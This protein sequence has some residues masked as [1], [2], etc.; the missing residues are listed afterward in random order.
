MAQENGSGQHVPVLLQAVLEGLNVRND[1]LYVDG[2]FGRGGHS[3]EI[4][5]RLGTK[6]RLLAI[7]RDPQAV[8]AAGAL[9][10]GDARF[11][12]VRG[13]IAELSE[14]VAEH[15]MLGKVDGLLFDLGVSSPQLDDPARGFSFRTD[16]PL[17]MRMDPT[18]GHSAADWLSRA[19]ETSL[20]KV[21]AEYG[22]ERFAARIARAIVTARGERAITRTSQ[23]ADIV[24]ASVPAR[25]ERIHPATRTFQALRIAV[26]DEL[27]QLERGLSAVPS[28]LARG[29]RFCAI[30]FHSLEDRRVKRF[31]RTASQESEQYR[32][33]PSIP[34][35]HRPP[36]HL[37]GKLVRAAPDEIAVNPRARSARLRVAERC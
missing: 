36:M 33:L 22:E 20:K 31:L 19:N 25:G 28:L 6:G 7:D 2:T 1:G 13:E 11:E 26:N 15:K 18:S 14:I 17:D 34:E 23:L 5:E 9:L 3:R 35:Q 32:G 8:E 4:L 27:G 29:G 24:A 12:I 30:S 10:G 21:L 16:G 37:I